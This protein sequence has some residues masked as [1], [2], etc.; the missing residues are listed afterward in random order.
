MENKSYE[1]HLPVFKQ[2]D[3]LSHSIQETKSLQEAFEKQAECYKLASDICLK[4]SET[5]KNHE[6]NINVVA[7][8]HYIGI[9]G[10]TDILEKLVEDGT[11]DEEENDEDDD[12]DFDE[13]E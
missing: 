7:D 12:D 3:D 9:S 5:I 11:L 1:L 13:E 2:G 10:P 4:I 8:T 6:E